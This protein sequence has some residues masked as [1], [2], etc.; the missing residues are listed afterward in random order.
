MLEFDISKLK[1]LGNIYDLSPEVKVIEETGDDGDVG[2]DVGICRYMTAST[3][4]HE[5]ISD[6][7][8]IER[9]D[10]HDNGPADPV[11]PPHGPHGPPNTID[12]DKL[13]EAT[14]WARKELQELESNPAD[15]VREYERLSAQAR[16]N[17]KAA[18]NVGEV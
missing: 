11:H 15:K 18:A 1:R 4:E 13:R 5:L 16:K 8:L 17:S 14:E 2:D 12:S 7:K 3:A 10:T 6:D 9:E